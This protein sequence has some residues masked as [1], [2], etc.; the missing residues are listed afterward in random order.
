MTAAVPPKSLKDQVRW[1]LWLT[2]AVNFVAFY[3]VCQTD[4]LAVSG[5]TGLISGAANLLPVG[6]ALIVTSIINGLLD[7]EAK[8]CLVFLRWNE[9]LPGHR[10]FSTYGPDDPRV[11]MDQL[12]KALGNQYPST[13]ADENRVWYRLYREIQTDPAVIHIH[14]E[15]LLNRDYAAFAALFLIGFGPAALFMVQSWRVAILYC[16]GLL[17]QFVFV[18]RAAAT[19]GIRFVTTVLAIQS[20]KPTRAPA[21]AKT[22]SPPGRSGLR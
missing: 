11:H 4:A 16:A 17:A 8:A 3:L 14:R 18:R 12:K 13:S 22:T 1:Q 2:I 20:T 10:A 19:Y 7:A 9:A 15:F 21:K 5:W 6:L